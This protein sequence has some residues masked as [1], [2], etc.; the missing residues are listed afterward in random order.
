MTSEREELVHA[1][2]YRIESERDDNRPIEL[3]A[4]ELL[5]WLTDEDPE[6][7]HREFIVSELTRILADRVPEMD[8]TI[9]EELLSR[10]R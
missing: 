7:L 3:K 5:G 10:L 8:Y 9:E 1:L 4:H 6:G 2:I